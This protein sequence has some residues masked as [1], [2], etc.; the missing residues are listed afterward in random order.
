MKDAEKITHVKKDNCDRII[1]FKTDANHVYDYETAKE[2]IMQ[3]KITN[4]RIK[5]KNGLDRI[6]E[7][8]GDHFEN[9]PPFG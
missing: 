6:T 8:N 9:F 3:Q 1:E 5:R 4:A 2:I 7:L